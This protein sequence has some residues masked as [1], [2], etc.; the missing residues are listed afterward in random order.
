MR[1][2]RSIGG[3]IFSGVGY[4]SRSATKTI[5]SQVP[6]QSETRILHKTFYRK[7]RM[8]ANDY[9]SY[10]LALKLKACSFDGPCDKC[11]KIIPGTEREEW[12]EEECQWCT[13]QDVEYYPKITL[14]Q[15]QKWLREKHH[16]S[17]RV[18]YLPLSGLWFSDWLNIES[19]EY[20]DTDAKFPTYEEALSEGVK[21][22]LELIKNGE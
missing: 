19:M 4:R 16:I 6:R 7:M 2:M 20:D 9:A 10:D 3:R 1:G 11:F 21:S 5:L 12:D 22:A 17:I 18:N 13:V 15:A 8:E 14:W